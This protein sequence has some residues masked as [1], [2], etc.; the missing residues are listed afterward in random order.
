MSIDEIKQLLTDKCD[1][2]DFSARMTAGRIASMDKESYDA[3][4]VWVETGEIQNLCY[5]DYSVEKLIKEYEL[6][7]P[8]AFLTI[9][10]LKGDYDNVAMILESGSK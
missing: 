6:K 4:M 10:D 7:I 2:T 9:S 5:R 3:F 1:Y 8:A